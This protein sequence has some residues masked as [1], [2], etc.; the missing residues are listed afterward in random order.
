MKKPDFNLYLVRHKTSLVIRLDPFARRSLTFIIVINNKQATHLP[1]ITVENV[2][3]E[4]D[5]L[6]AGQ[7]FSCPWSGSAQSRVLQILIHIHSMQSTHTIFFADKIV[8]A[9]DANYT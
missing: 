4:T 6:S 9:S 8:R 7:Q 1:G 5:N 3:P 2:E